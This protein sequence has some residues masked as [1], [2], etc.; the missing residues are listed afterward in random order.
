MRVLL[1][2]IAALPF[3]ASFAPR[4]LPPTH[5]RTSLTLT[6]ERTPERSPSLLTAATLDQ[7]PTPTT[8]SYNN[9][10]SSGLSGQA[11]RNDPTTFPT[12]GTLK[13]VIPKDCFK[14]DTLTSLRYL[15]ISVAAS[16]ACVAAGFAALPIVGTSPLSIPFWALYAAVAGTVEMGLW[17][18]AHECGHGAF[19]KD[20]RIQ[21]T[22]GFVIHSIL[23][24]PY[25]SWQRSHA[26][27]HRYTNHME[28]GETHVPEVWS[29]DVNEGSS[30]QRRQKLVDMFG[31]EAGLKMWGSL[32]AVLHLV[33]GWPAYER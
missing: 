9:V 22:V 4:P 27:H 24:V 30:I 28:L 33:F 17:V 20:L 6:P 26:V 10:L 15:S 1:T 19:S 31:E 8:P 13:S 29:E 12:A 32:Q 25:Y 5:Q 14:V 21:D 16:A 3:T 18:L 23:L 2:I 7:L 11:L